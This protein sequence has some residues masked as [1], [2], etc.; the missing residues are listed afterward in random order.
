MRGG[1]FTPTPP[2][3][4]KVACINFGIWGHVLDSINH[5]KFQLDRFRGFKAQMAENH[6]LSLTGDIALT[7]LCTNVRHCDSHFKCC[8]TQL[9]DALLLMIH[10][11]T[12][13][14]TMLF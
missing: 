2:Y 12:L 4:P 8:E 6:Y 5:A 9:H 13:L 1:N 3:T 14:K 7:T 10:F 11:C